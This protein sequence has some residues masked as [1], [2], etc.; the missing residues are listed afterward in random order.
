WPWWPWSFC[1]ASA[2]TTAGRPDAR[3]ALTPSS[4]SSRRP[5]SDAKD[6]PLDLAPT[7]LVGLGGTGKDVLLRIRRLFFQREGKRD[8]YIG[9]PIISYL[10]LDTDGAGFASIEWEDL[11]AYVLQNIQF[12]QGD[13]REMIDCSVKPDQFTQ[14][15]EGGKRMHPHIFSWM[16]PDMYRY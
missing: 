6:R 15:F 2:T 13:E 14:Y 11:T 12:R 7:I 9:Y 1:S 16:L 5:P 4:R 8:Y 10:A 3:P